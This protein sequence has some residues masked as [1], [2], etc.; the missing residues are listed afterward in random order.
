MTRIAALIP[1]A[2]AGMLLTGP[3]GAQDL[4]QPG[5][6]SEGVVQTPSEEEARPLAGPGADA[7][8]VR[9]MTHLGLN[10]GQ[11]IEA[12]REVYPAL[13]PTTVY[14]T[15]AEELVRHYSAELTTEGDVKLTLRFDR[16]KHL[17]HIESTQLL[18][19]GVAPTALRQRVESKYG[20]ADVTGRMGLGVFRIGYS[21]PRAELNVIADIA[22]AGRDAPSMI[23][24]ELID[25]ALE[26][27]NEASYRVE[28]AAQGKQPGPPP[29]GDTRVQL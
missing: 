19:P 22:L 11:S 27:E 6:R 2:A 24:I 18:R 29:A 9:K 13:D 12:V 17:Y 4:T 10:L 25:H 1:L 5:A 3:V 20:P 26:A 14:G 8:R 23:R 16:Q 7:S 15:A 28:A 21:D